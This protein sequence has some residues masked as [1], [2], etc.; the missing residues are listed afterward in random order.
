MKFNTHL[1]DFAM[2]K[3]LFNRKDSVNFYFARYIGEKCGNKQ[4]LKWWCSVKEI[5]VYLLC[6]IVISKL[7]PLLQKNCREPP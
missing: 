5:E 6:E 7:L 2:T 3:D 4:K 1:N